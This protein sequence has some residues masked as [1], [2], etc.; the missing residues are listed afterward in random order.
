MYGVYTAYLCT[1]LC[2]DGWPF[3]VVVVVGLR[4][5]NRSFALHLT[6]TARRR[7]RRRGVNFKPQ[8][9]HCRPR[10]VNRFCDR[11]R[12][13]ASSIPICRVL[14]DN[15]NN[16]NNNI[17]N[18]QSCRRLSPRPTILSYFW[19][20]FFRKRTCLLDVPVIHIIHVTRNNNIITRSSTP[21]TSLG[22][23]LQWHTHAPVYTGHRT[24]VERVSSPFVCYNNNI[25][26]GADSVCARNS[27]TTH[28]HIHANKHIV[29]IMPTLYQL[30]MPL[31]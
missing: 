20:P 10:F 24:G 7:W 2:A 29:S 23:L 15:S 28:T 11:S 1:L 12:Y 17:T 18:K 26:I 25:I 3:V 13:A 31:W 6:P 14:Y 16:N 9:H 27:A 19:K 22:K 5:S 8:S 4:R 30:V 21:Q